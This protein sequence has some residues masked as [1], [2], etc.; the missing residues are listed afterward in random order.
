MVRTPARVQRTRPAE[1]RREDLIRSAERL[2]LARGV[3]HTSIEEITQGASVSKGAFYLHFSSKTDVIEAIRADFVKALL[4]RVVE[5]VD[6]QD[7]SGWT[8]KLKAW[9]EAC[10]SG[11]L[12]AARLHSFIFAVAPL[13]SRE[14]LTRNS[15]IDCLSDLLAAGSQ[16]NAWSIETPPFTAAFLFNALH[17]VVNQAGAATH[18]AGRAGLLHEIGVHFE[19]IVSPITI[20]R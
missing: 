20:A 15:L 13:P 17:G 11:Y 10:A 6:N 14:G 3:E 12:D 1:E 5:A 8:A 4:A 9:A 19:R 7:P 16:A 2:F 18:P